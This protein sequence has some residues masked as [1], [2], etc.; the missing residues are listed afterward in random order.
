MLSG[1]DPRSDSDI[2]IRE[3]VQAVES[4]RD[5]VQYEVLVNSAENAESFF[6]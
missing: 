3:L 1:G 2:D 5:R 4:A 6:Y